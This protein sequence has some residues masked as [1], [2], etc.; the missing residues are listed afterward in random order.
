MTVAISGHLMRAAE[1][2]FSYAKDPSEREA[3]VHLLVHAGEGM[4]VEVRTRFGSGDAAK[5]RGDNFAHACH[6]GSFVEA[7]GSLMSMRTDHDVAAA[8]MGRVTSL[9]VNG[10]PVRLGA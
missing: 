4:P 5:L 2:R 9:A 7:A 1:C 10:T 3:V 6:L 8:I